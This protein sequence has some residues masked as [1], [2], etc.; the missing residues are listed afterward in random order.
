MTLEDVLSPKYVWRKPVFKEYMS[1]P[2]CVSGCLVLKSMSAGLTQIDCAVLP[3][4]PAARWPM[5]FSLRT[6]VSVSQSDV[7]SVVV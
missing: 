2:Q 5:G 3:V 4:C 1:A 7:L 6:S